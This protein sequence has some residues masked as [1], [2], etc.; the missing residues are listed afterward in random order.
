MH[1]DQPVEPPADILL[2]FSK[3]PENLTG[4]SKRTIES[5][6]DAAEVK[7]VPQKAVGR[8]GRGGRK[9]QVKP[10]SGLD[11][12]SLLAD[13]GPG[14]K[15]AKTISR[16]N[17][18]PEFKQALATAE[19]DA[20]VEGAARQMGDIVRGLINDSF[21]NVFYERATENLRVMREQLVEF[22][23]PG[24]YNKFVRS[25][26]KSILSGELDGDRREMWL[27]HIVGEKLG[28]VT[29]E[30]SEVSE[31]TADE[32]S[33]VSLGGGGPFRGLVLQCAN[34]WVALVLEVNLTT[35][36]DREKKG[37]FS[38]ASNGV[39]IIQGC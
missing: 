5:L 18:V 38:L 6:I 23:V 30:E 24:L 12:D 1:P 26:K 21:A 35:R 11:I 16:E 15:R 31:V 32:A 3:P 22:E 28:L 33:E 19:D 20:T 34:G 9:D 2:R 14:A 7:K 37:V 8:S 27:K 36:Y 25:L 4:K 13:D 39:E 10:L 17:A 29:S